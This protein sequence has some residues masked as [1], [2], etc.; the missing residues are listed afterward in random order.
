MLNHLM[1]VTDG[2]DIGYSTATTGLANFDMG[3]ERALET[4]RKRKR[5]P[6]VESNAPATPASV[7]PFQPGLEV[8][9][10]PTWCMEQGYLDLDVS[11]DI[12]DLTEANVMVPPHMYAGDDQRFIDI[13]QLVA[14]QAIHQMEITRNILNLTEEEDDCF[15]NTLHSTFA[16]T[17]EIFSRILPGVQ[18]CDLKSF[19]ELD[20]N[21]AKNLSRN[22]ISQQEDIEKR[23]QTNLQARANN[24]EDEVFFET[25]VP[26]LNVQRGQ[27]ALDISPPALCFWEE[28]GLGPSQHRRDIE[29]VCIYPDSPAIRD[30]ALTFMATLQDSYQSCKFGF[31]RPCPGPMNVQEGLLPVSITSTDPDVLVDSFVQVCEAL[32]KYQA[33]TL[34][35]P[36]TFN[37]I[38]ME[39]P[40]KEA[41]GTNIVVYF[42]DPFDDD[43]MSPYICA[44]FRELYEAYAISAMKAG[45]TIARAL[46][47]QIVPLSFLAS[48]ESLTI[49]PPKSYTKLAFEV[50]SRC[51]PGPHSDGT[52]PSP[53]ISG[54]AIRLAKPIPKTINFQLSSQ[55]PGNL[56]SP[57]PCLHLAYSWDIDQQWLACAWT[58]NFGATQWST[59]YCLGDRKTD[60]WTA[61]AETVKEVLDTTRDLLQ[62]MTIPW[63]IYVVKDNI[64]Y[65]RE[66]ESK[67]T[68]PS[69][70]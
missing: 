20:L 45:L 25:R 39:L 29:A 22:K 49:P 69:G 1:G 42:V 7:S 30:A 31:H 28:L 9:T 24:S 61:F 65:D 36:L 63:K 26:Y 13:A 40:L 5:G 43:N 35:H 56:L 50:Y 33:T 12:A 4:T 6:S 46:V 16:L 67:Y 11:N 2:E 68:I 52:I 10:D 23:R 27:D 59:I 66:L 21:A 17:H 18:H 38:G 44:A 37:S 14:D 8:S 64:F 51:K 41:D 3:S 54:S 15:S 34:A 62:P 19:S 55:P 57:D 53:S 32:G 47:L 60:Y 58:D 70:V 48:S